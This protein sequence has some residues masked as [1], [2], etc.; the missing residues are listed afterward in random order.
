MRKAWLA[1]L[2]SVAAAAVALAL[3]ASPASA[4]SLVEVTGFGTN[5]TGLKMHLYVPDKLAANPH[6]LDEQIA[7]IAAELETRPAHVYANRD[8]GFTWDG[9]PIEPPAPPPRRV[10]EPPRRERRGIVN[11]RKRRLP[12]ASY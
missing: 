5:P 2:V 7:R 3:P 6:Y 1:G 8:K 4:A 11:A 12:P 9:L 10:S